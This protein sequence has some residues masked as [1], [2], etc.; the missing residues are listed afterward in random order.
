[1]KL[2]VIIRVIELFQL[3]N[4]QNRVFYINFCIVILLLCEPSLSSSTKEDWMEVVIKSFKIKQCFHSTD[5][6]KL[7]VYQV[8]G[9]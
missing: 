8:T 1:M 5:F 6:R 7:V 3:Y 4:Q 9:T 2:Q